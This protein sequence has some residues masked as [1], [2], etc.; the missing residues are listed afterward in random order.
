MSYPVCMIGPNNNILKIIY[1]PFRIGHSFDIAPI[2]PRF[3]NWP[4]ANSK[5]SNGIPQNIITKKYGIKNIPK[6]NH[7]CIIKYSIITNV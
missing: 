4:I 6:I 5:Y 2:G 1:L 7:W 3:V